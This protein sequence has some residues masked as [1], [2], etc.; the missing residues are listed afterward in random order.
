LAITAYDSRVSQI[1]DSQAAE[2][3]AAAWDDFVLAI[4]RS[5]ARGQQSPDGL[6]LAQYYLLVPLLRE[7]SL[8]LSQLAEAAGVSAPTATRLVDGLEQS[9]LVVR[10]RSRRDRRTVLISLTPVG[11]QRLKRRQRQLSRRRRLLYERLEP[12]ERDQSERLL[13]HLAELIGQL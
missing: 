10:E 1:S 7:P 5:Q 2:R 11:R 9:G 13:R 8:P 12:A 6:S 4:R 3:F